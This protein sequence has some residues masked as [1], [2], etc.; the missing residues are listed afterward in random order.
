M[1]YIY[2]LQETERQRE[3]KEDIEHIYTVPPHGM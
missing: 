2:V 3:K 1:N